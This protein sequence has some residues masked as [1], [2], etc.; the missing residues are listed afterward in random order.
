MP[1]LVFFMLNYKFSG[2]AAISFLI[3]FC[4]NQLPV[5]MTDS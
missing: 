3:L 5:F 2:I 1:G 4:L